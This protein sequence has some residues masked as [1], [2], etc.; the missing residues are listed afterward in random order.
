MYQVPIYV[1][2]WSWSLSSAIGFFVYFIVDSLVTFD[3]LQ[4]MYLPSLFLCKIG[5]SCLGFIIF[6]FL[7]S[8]WNSLM[9]FSS[10]FLWF[11]KR[12]LIL[13]P[14]MVVTDLKN[15]FYAFSK[16]QKASSGGMVMLDQK[17]TWCRGGGCGWPW[18]ALRNLAKNGWIVEGRTGC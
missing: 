4:H 9:S 6:F 5:L 7:L 18:Q 2:P 12:F 1:W 14:M 13:S 10:C 16:R 8:F 11:F 3:F 15:S 17:V